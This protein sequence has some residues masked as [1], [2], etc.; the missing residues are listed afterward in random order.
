VLE[1]GPNWQSRMRERAAAHPA[2]VPV[3][4]GN[5]YGFGR[6]RLR[7]ECS[8]L[9]VDEVAVGTIHELDDGRNGRRTIVLTPAL[10]AEI[11]VAPAA[12]LHN[13]ILTIGNDRDRAAAEG[14]P[15]IVKVAGSLHRYGY[16]LGAL[17][18]DVQQLHGYALHLPLDCT[19]AEKLAEVSEVASLLPHGSTFYVSHLAPSEEADVRA[20]CPHLTIRQR[21][22]TALWLGDKLDVRL[23]ADVVEVRPVAAGT[24]AGYRQ[25]SVARDGNLIMVTAGTAHGVGPLPDG[26]S[27]FHF[28]RNRL[29]LH[30]PPHMHTSMLFVPSGEACPQ[31]GDQVDVQQP[32]TRVWP[33]VVR[34]RPNAA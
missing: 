23:A 13:A 31:P 2:L 24:K 22:G 14:R 11:A 28:A 20:A 10:A 29:A 9:G 25:G 27:P 30:E 6:L 8:A 15:V 4:K 26:R 12:F 1:V 32:L 21:I 16:G 33:D 3:V 19:S 18:T 34:D 5:G 7:N 17:P